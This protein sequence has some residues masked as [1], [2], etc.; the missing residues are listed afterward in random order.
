M[1][2]RRRQSRSD[3]IDCREVA[4][5]VQ[6]F[7][8]GEIIDPRAVR[9]ADHLDTC[10]TCGLEADTYR[11]LKAAI[12]GLARADDPRQLERLQRFVDALTPGEAG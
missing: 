4:R 8:D 12:A 3:T 5:L 11:W 7:L 6:A 9:V 2:V 10:L 1:M